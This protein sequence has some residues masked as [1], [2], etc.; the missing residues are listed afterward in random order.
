MIVESKKR[1]NLLQ[2][3]RTFFPIIVWLPQYNLTKLKGDL[4]AGLTV[5]IMVVPQGIAFA[6]V[7]GLPIQY[8][9]YTSLTPGLIYCIFGTSKDVNVG[10]TATMSLFTNKLNTTKS[11]IGSS[12]LGFWC[13]IVLFAVGI[14]RLGFVSKFV[15]YHVINAFVSAAA[16]TIAVSQFPNLLGIKGA[17]SNTF[18]ILDYLRQKIKTTNKYDVTLGILCMVYLGFFMWLSKRKFITSSSGFKST[19]IIF[20]KI[21]LLVCSARMVLVCIFATI[22]VYIFYKHGITTKFSVAGKLPKGMPKW[23]VK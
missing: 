4:I 18:L 13:G 9:L 19:R 20:N 5:G 14:F 15:P 6:T 12:L 17:P 10:P 7:A 22:A 11:P 21:V 16:I 2:T 23:Q 1:F 3:L 8:G